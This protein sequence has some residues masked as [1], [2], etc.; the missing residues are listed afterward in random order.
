MNYTNF[1]P[2]MQYPYTS[3]QQPQYQQ[4]NQQFQPQQFQSQP[5]QQ[6]TYHPLTF[7]NGIEGAKAF[8]VA[9][10]QIMYLKDSD[11]N[12]LYEKRADQ[13]GKY[14]LIAYELMQKDLNNNEKPTNN[15]V[16]K[17]DLKEYASR[18]DLEA[19]KSIFGDKLDILSSK[20]EKLQGGQ[21]NAK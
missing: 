10:N 8:I 3:Y 16:I 9:P 1:N 13:N 19:L 17:E 6:T 2:Y 11:S 7:V 4:Q 14:T 12:M 5:Q 21:N 18:S 15:Y 20:L